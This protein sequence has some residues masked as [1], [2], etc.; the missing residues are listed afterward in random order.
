[1]PT[2]LIG[3]AEYPQIRAAIDVSLDATALP[4]AVLALPIF[5]PAAIAE[6]L[7]RDPL[8]EARTDPTEVLHV[9]SAAIYFAAARLAARGATG[10][11]RERYDDYEY[12]LPTLDVA[13]LIADLRALGEA[14]VALVPEVAAALGARGASGASVDFTLAPAGRRRSAPWWRP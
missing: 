5:V 9:Q 3:P 2:P 4:D 13:A 12:T 7:A 6:V 14:E 10:P 11:T 1:M 8:A